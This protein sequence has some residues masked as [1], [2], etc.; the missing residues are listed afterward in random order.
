MAHQVTNFNRFATGSTSYLLPWLALTAQLPYETGSAGA[1]IMS[2]CIGLGSPMLMIISLMMTI[3]NKRWIRKKFGWSLSEARRIHAH[4]MEARAQAAM[5]IAEDA[6]QVPVRLIQRDGWLARQ[7]VLDVYTTW[8]VDAAES[9][10]STRR[11]VTLSLVAQLLVA[12]IS[13]IL[14]IVGSLTKNVGDTAEALALSSGSL[15]IWLVS[16]PPVSPEPIINSMLI[17]QLT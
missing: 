17:V 7:I 1:D 5:V 16:Y 15:W 2:V 9:L 4:G 3:L 8:W 10:K 13:W 12:V 6:Q 11:G 14:T